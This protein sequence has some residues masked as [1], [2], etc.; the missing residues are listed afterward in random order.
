MM[1]GCMGVGGDNIGVS[2]MQAI[3]FSASFTSPTW[4]GGGHTAGNIPSDRPYLECF[5]F[6]GMLFLKWVVVVS[7]SLGGISR[8][9]VPSPAW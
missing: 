3:S 8:L 4:R 9:K 1:P 7:V 6:S 2:G 5:V